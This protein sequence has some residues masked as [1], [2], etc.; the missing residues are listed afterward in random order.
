MLG[1]QLEKEIEEQIYLLPKRADGYRQTLGNLFPTQAADFD[2]ILLAA[3]GSSDHAALYGRY[4]IEI[5]LGIPAILAAPSVLTRF[6]VHVRYPK[7]LCVGLSQ[8]GAAPDV[9]EVLADARASGHRTLAI[10]NTAGSKV[11][12][13][14]ENTLLLD[15]GPEKSLAATK[16]YSASLLALALLVQTLGGELPPLTLPDAEWLSVCRARAKEATRFVNHARTCFSL[17]RGFS[18]ASA[19]EATLKL[20]ECALIP[21]KGYS[22]ADFQ[23]GPKALA[24]PGSVALV[25]GEP[26]KGLAEQGCR[27]IPCPV[28]PC[29]EPYLPIWQAIFAQCLA[30]QVA[31]SKRLDPDTPPFLQKITRTL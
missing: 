31:R 26:P 4:L 9:A 7:C 8:S 20:M 6:G 21:A 30:L 24:G 27:L 3:R 14:A 10:T 25:F 19:Q 22:T 1:A 5:F 23:H 16:T 29:E 15:L 13:A 17:G 28:P 11:T 2:C 18:F 12:K